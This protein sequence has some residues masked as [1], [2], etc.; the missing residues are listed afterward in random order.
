MRISGFFL[1]ANIGHRLVSR[2]NSQFW[3][4]KPQRNLRFKKKHDDAFKSHNSHVYFSHIAPSPLGFQNCVHEQRLLRIS[5]VGRRGAAVG[6]VD[7]HL[8]WLRSLRFRDCHIEHAIGQV[9]LDVLVADVV[10]QPERA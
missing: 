8:L 1:C 4:N 9:G 5:A 6:D 7:L 10:R 3:R 2:N